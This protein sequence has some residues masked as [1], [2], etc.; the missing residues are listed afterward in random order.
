MKPIALL[1]VPVDHNSSFLRGCAAGPA[2]IRKAL[3]CD[4]TN[5][6]AEDGRDLGQP[7]L[8]FDAG[9][10]AWPDEA[11]SHDAVLSAAGV[12]LDGGHRLLSLGGDHSITFPLFQAHAE[13]F[14]GLAIVHFDAH[15]DLYD[16]YEGQPF[17]HA[18]P[19][20]RI[21]ERGLA[22]SLTQVGIRT[23]NPPQRRQVERFGVR[24]FE[25]R[26]LDHRPPE[27]PVGPTYLSIDLDVL[28]PAF[29]PGVS[30]HEPG[31][32]STRE[33][34][35]Y[36]RQIRGPIVGADLVELN[37]ARDRDDVTARVAAKLVKEILAKMVSAPLPDTR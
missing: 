32:L 5:L 20:A 18:S 23:L 34:L 13:R 21:L 3:H 28:D 35:G 10:V 33:L 2:A 17:S 26:D 29:V 12:V 37:P 16:D 36:L 9:D 15:P 31:G 4:S 6:C 30:H 24:V 27:F 14:P 8:W 22:A 11:T 1:G 19:F 25:A 7:G